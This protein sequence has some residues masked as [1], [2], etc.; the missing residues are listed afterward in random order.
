MMLQRLLRSTFLASA[1][2]LAAQLGHA[3]TPVSFNTGDLLIGFHA[4]G[5]GGNTTGVT[6]T[7]VVNAGS[8]RTLA[9]ATTTITLPNTVKADLD[10]IYGTSW[11]T[12][13]DLF[14]GAAAAT[15]GTDVNGDPHYTLYASKVQTTVGTPNASSARWKRQSETTQGQPAGKI[16]TAGQGYKFEVGGAPAQSTAN[17]PVG[18]I[19]LNA[20]GDSWASYQSPD[21]VADTSHTGATRVCFAYFNFQDGATQVGIQDTFANG[22]AGAALELYRMAPSGGAVPT[23]TPGDYLGTLTI[24]DNGTI[25]FTPDTTSARISLDQAAYSL[26]EAD[27]SGKV[28]VSLTRSR[29]TGS[30]ATAT[31]NTTAGTAVANTD[32]TPLTNFVVTFD[33]GQTTKMVDIP[34]FKRNGVQADKTFSVSI[35]AVS[36]GATVGFVGTSNVT[37]TESEAGATFSSATYSFQED[38]GNAVIVVNRAGNPTIPFTVDFSTADGDGSGNPAA[39]QQ[40]PD[41]DYT[42][43]T[44][45]GL[46]FAANDS[47]PKTINVPLIN[48]VGLQGSRDFKVNLTNITGAGASLVTPSTAIVTITDKPGNPGEIAFAAATF[49]A[50]PLNVL[51][52]P[53][54]ITVPISRTNGTTGTVAAN[55]AVTGGT[56]VNGTDFNMFATTPVTFNDGDG[57][58]TVGIQLKSPPKAGTIVLTL[59]SP[60]NGAT[61]GTVATTTITVNAI[62]KVL[63]KVTV[64]SPKSGTLATGITAFD[65]TGTATDDRGVDHVEITINGVTSNVVPTVGTGAF[66]KTSV[67]A[68]NGTNTVVI[69]AVDLNGNRSKPITKTVTFINNRPLLAGT[70]NGLL[71]PVGTKSHEKSGLVTLTVKATGTFSGKVNIGSFIIPVTGIVGNDNKVHF[72]PTLGTVLTLTGK[73]KVPVQFGLLTLTVATD[74]VTGSLTEAD[75]TTVKANV[76]GDR[77]V[78]DGKTPLTTVPAGLL[79]VPGGKKGFYTVRFP[80]KTQTPTVPPT[81]YPQSDGFGTITITPKGAVT[82]K[83]TLADGTAV[84]ASVPLSK[85]FEAPFYAKLYKKLGS[86]AG[87]VVFDEL[88]ATHADT[89]VAGADFLWFRP[90]MLTQ[91]Y[92]PN[93]WPTGIAVNLAGAKYAVPTNSTSVLL[94]LDPVGSGTGNATLTFSLGKLN[95]TPQL[96]NLD[97]APNNKVTPLVVPPATK[98]SFALKIVAASGAISGTF[99]HTPDNAKTAYKGAILQKGTNTGGFGYF[100]SVVPKGSVVPGE[101]GAV[102][103][104]AK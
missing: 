8:A 35:T 93:G 94:G 19:E 67:A 15:D 53:S 50:E 74:K 66:S 85:T 81:D 102:V 5:V 41:N 76:D 28:T 43:T 22:T 62:D 23:N 57:S 37:L 54:L 95:P 6:Q 21:G 75:G 59:S 92:Y 24:N 68:E 36:A 34:I 98:P 69:V 90:Q 58:E 3:Q 88:V 84:S 77:G 56:L 73:A 4:T 100:L 71:V 46:S 18:V 78:F 13:A 45:T 86:I 47:T 55:V 39:H 89:D 12:R 33:P 25:T 2:F 31:L 80:A 87:Q 65:V 104:Q 51:K 29:N 60:N 30:T 14:W 16:A 49:T 17:N 1:G 79:N 26:S 11:K 83:G 20:E 103:L 61:L 10:A 48:R 70:Y 27:A 91:K 96:N 99:T 72:K 63:P 101:S 82:L 9:D 44:M 40:A 97:V 7:Y 64:T 32:F 52:M 42:Q 38:A